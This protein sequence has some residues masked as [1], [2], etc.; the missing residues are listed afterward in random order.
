MNILVPS[1][2]KVNPRIDDS[3]EERSSVVVRLAVVTSN[4]VV[5]AY[6]LTLYVSNT[7]NFVPSLLNDKE[8]G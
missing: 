3:W 1:L 2:L 8:Y 6:S 7:N 5:R 4:P